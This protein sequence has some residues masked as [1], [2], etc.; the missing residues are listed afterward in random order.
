M[1]L[2]ENSVYN[3]KLLATKYNKIKKLLNKLAIINEN[4]LIIYEN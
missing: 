3:L 4:K 2:F 1:F